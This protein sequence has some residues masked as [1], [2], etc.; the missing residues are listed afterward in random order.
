MP[1]DAPNEPMYSSPN[2]SHG[3]LEKFP[4]LDDAV[5]PEIAIDT[6]TTAPATSNN[7]DA[8]M[9]SLDHCMLRRTHMAIYTS[10][11]VVGLLDQLLTIVA[12]QTDVNSHHGDTSCAS[13]FCP[14]YE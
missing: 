3:E 5:L 1:F 4:D 13:H 6:S 11:T 9:R 12:L 14:L 7:R 8:G 10:T 2:A